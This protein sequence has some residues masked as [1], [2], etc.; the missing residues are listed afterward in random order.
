MSA[1]AEILF[2]FVSNSYPKR[3]RILCRAAA[4]SW[5]QDFS[6][7]TVQRNYLR[8]SQSIDFLGLDSSLTEALRAA[9]V[10]EVGQLADMEKDAVG[11]THKVSMC[12]APADTVVLFAGRS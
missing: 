1:L 4:A 11:Y 9:G 6:N 3:S 7:S 12:A 2:A 5:T 10:E 8:E